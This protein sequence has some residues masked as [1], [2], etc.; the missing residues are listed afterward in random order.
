MKWGLVGAS[1][2]ASEHVIGA[3]RANEHEI[4]SVLSSDVARGAD[5]AARH[6]IPGSHTDLDEMLTRPEIDAVYI[7]TTNEKHYPQAMLAIAAGKHVLCEKPLAMTLDE[8]VEMV[9]AAEAKGVT[10][11]TNH[12]LRNAGSH[13][14]IRDLIAGGRLGRILS[15]RVMQCT[16]RLISKAGGSTT[17]QRAGE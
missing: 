4:L 8:A 7:S 15:V 14:A 11:A 2:I 6:G 12:H 13:L 17:P 16:C 5:Y 1:T 10:F 9:H 3:I